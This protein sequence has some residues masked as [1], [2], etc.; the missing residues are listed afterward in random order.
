MEP[1]SRNNR[2]ARRPLN[3]QSIRGYLM[4]IIMLLV[5]GAILFREKLNLELNGFPGG[6]KMA[7]A[8]AVLCAI[9]GI[10][11]I[12]LAYRNAKNWQDEN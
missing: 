1:K 8:F 11:R 7:T 9:Y 3:L 10:W 12:Y 4:G 5:S 6:E 2:P